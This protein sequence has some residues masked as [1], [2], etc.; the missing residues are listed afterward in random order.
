MQGWRAPSYQDTNQL[1]NDFFNITYNPSTGSYIFRDDNGF[2]S[3]LLIVEN[4]TNLFGNTY[5]EGLEDVTPNSDNEYANNSISAFSA[6]YTS[7]SLI[8]PFSFESFRVT[9]SALDTY[10]RTPSAQRYEIGA[11]L[12]RDVREVNS[13]TT[14]YLMMTACFCLFI[15]R[16]HSDK[17]QHS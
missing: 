8:S 16:R 14:A 12:V 3:N 4:F 11:W 7:P 13:P 17:A 5:Y 15:R 9:S 6:G 1:L 2:R 10:S